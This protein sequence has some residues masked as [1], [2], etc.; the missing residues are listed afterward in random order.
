MIIE[1]YLSREIL[2]PFG[3]GLGL[4]VLV[5]VGYSLA[6]QLTLAAAGQVDLLTAGRLVLLRT[7]VVLEVLLPSALFFSVLAGLGR[8]YRDGEMSALYAA[9]VSRLRILGAVFFLGLAIAAVTGLISVEGRP[10]AYR[11]S[12][13]LQAQ[14]SAEFDLKKM[15]TGEFVTMGDSDY[16]FIADDLDLDRGLHK[17]VFLQK[18]HDDGARAELI[19]AERAALPTLNPSEPL[20]ATFYDG[21]HY[22][23]DNRAQLD[24][25]MNFG[26]LTIRLPGTE[27]QERYRRKAEPTAALR[28]SGR[29]KD[30]AEYQ[31]RIT[32]PLATVLLALIAVPLARSAP[33]ES[34]TRSFL[35]AIG[36]YVCLFAITSA[37]RTGME[38]GTVPQ[39]PGLWGT[40][41]VFA[42][43]LVLLLWPPRLPGRRR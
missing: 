1:R 32:T 27:A 38:Q 24:V 34:R 22:L 43:L 30:I 7:V 18:P 11:E 20:T 5:F 10:W 42:V 31:W 2:R 19:Y 40:Y 4:L 9:G 3:L 6:R 35:V 33:R 39:M 23:L 26:T 28:R 13:R 15:A 29:P 16:T 36:A 25:T 8:L 41:G 17:T 21:Y 37:V 12:Y 14:A